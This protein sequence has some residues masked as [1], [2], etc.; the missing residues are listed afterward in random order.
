MC[1]SWSPANTCTLFVRV[2]SLNKLMYIYNQY[3]AHGKPKYYVTLLAVVAAITI[4]YTSYIFSKF[5][6]ALIG[7]ERNNYCIE[8]RKRRC[9]SSHVLQ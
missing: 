3:L 4:N 8:E 1:L 9:Y 7:E 5:S 2:M 6:S